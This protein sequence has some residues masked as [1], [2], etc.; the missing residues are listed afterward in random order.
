[1]PDGFQQR[2]RRFV[3]KTKRKERMIVQESAKELAI[4]MQR[5]VA[6]GGSMPV[7]DGNLRNSFLVAINGTKVKE[8]G[9]AHMTA[10]ALYKNGD[11][12]F[13]G[14]TAEYAR[15]MEYGFDDV[16]SLGRAYNQQGY[17]FVR[18]AVQQWD[19]IVKANARSI[20]RII[21]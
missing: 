5:P 7:V 8:G 12:I 19:S 21:R 13:M 16:D 20:D 18:L 4:R 3:E 1:M 15:R 17:G 6:Q 2:I 14:W 9:E 11:E 10:L